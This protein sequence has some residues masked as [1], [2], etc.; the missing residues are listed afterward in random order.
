[1]AIDDTLLYLPEP[2]YGYSILDISDPLNIDAVTVHSDDIADL[3]GLDVTENYAYVINYM[4]QTGENRNGHYAIEMS[5]KE[6]PYLVSFDRL[7]GNWR[8]ATVYN[9]LLFMS[10]RFSTRIYSLTDPANPAYLASYP[11]DGTTTKAAAARGN[12]LYVSKGSDFLVADIS[13]P[14]N[15]QE[16]S[17]INT[18]WL[19]TGDIIL[20]GNLAYVASRKTKDLGESHLLTIDISDPSNVTLVDSMFVAEEQPHLYWPETQIAMHGGY[21]YYAGGST[22][23]SGIDIGIPDAPEVVY[24]YHPQDE[25]FFDVACRRNYLFALGDNSLQIFDLTVPS[26]PELI[27]FLPMTSSPRRLKV[28]GDYLYI[29]CRW[30]FYIYEIGLPPVDCGDANADGGVDIDDVV[31][32]IAYIFSGGPAPDPLESGDVD[33]SGGVDIDD[34]VYLIM[35][36]FS[37]GNAPCDVDGDTVLDC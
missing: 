37:G 13:D 16:L 14:S 36:I 21:I 18:E 27:D 22:G 31:G 11:I 19:G 35:Y 32:I 17:L 7:P 23:L 28:D 30:G 5:D 8:D 25:I 29:S 2:T 3:K 15:P 26:Q 20:S 24:H 12:I 1:M 4:S 33:C 34:V 6:N 9:D 10:G